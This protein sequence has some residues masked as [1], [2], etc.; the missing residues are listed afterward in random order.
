MIAT[1]AQKKRYKLSNVIDG[2]ATTRINRKTDCCT[3]LT[4]HGNWVKGNE[5]EEDECRLCLIN[6]NDPFKLEFVLEQYEQQLTRAEL[7]HLKL[8][9]ILLKG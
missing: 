2:V 3:M 9:V 6:V 5:I 7:A 1:K 4:D 8:K